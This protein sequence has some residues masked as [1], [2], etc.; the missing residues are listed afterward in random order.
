[1]LCCPTDQ[2]VENLRIE[3]SD[4]LKMDVVLTGDVMYDAALCYSQKSESIG[5]EAQHMMAGIDSF[6]LATV[7]RAE[8]TDDPER[9]IQ[10]VDALNT[11]NR[12][13]HVILPLHPRTRQKID[14]LEL[15]LECTLCEPLGYFDMLTL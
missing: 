15:N 9:L 6:I 10:I 11:L 4:Q 1:L 13:T 2:A 12:H 7:H 14:T 8:N 5:K 3:G